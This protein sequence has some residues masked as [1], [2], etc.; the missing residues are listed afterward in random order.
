VE[1]CVCCGF[2]TGARIRSEARLHGTDRRLIDLGLAPFVRRVL[3]EAAAA[4]AAA[5]ILG[6][7]TLGGRVDA[8]VQ[9]RDAL[10][11][12]TVPTVAFVNKRAISAGALIALSAEKVVMVGGSTIGAA[13]PV[14]TGQ[15]GASALP[16][17]EKTVSY[18]R[19]EFRATAEARKR[20]PLLAE[21]MVDVDVAIEDM[22]EKGKL[23]TLTTDEALQHKPA[24]FRADTL[25]RSLQQLGLA[26]AQVRHLFLLM[27][28]MTEVN[29]GS[30]SSVEALRMR[31]SFPGPPTLRPARAWRAHVVPELA[32]MIRS[33][34]LEDCLLE[35]KAL[36]FPCTQWRF[37]S[38]GAGTSDLPE[39]VLDEVCE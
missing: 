22:V 14:Q 19:K 3:Q 26:G 29:R 13:T 8:A 34:G 9:I 28:S 39:H 30:T 18:V 7:N 31:G 32:R 33:L 17:E 5:V 2:R 11:T 6:I 10:L 4:G 37:I 27:P 1:S 20:P 25:E 12:A 15:P 21:A 35:S 36:P 16:V 23:L 38:G 24:D